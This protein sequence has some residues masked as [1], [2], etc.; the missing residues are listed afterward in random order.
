MDLNQFK[1]IIQKDGGKFIIVENDKPT[2]IVMSFDEY[3]GKFANRN[4]SFSNP[5][6][7]TYQMGQTAQPS[8][9]GKG[10]EGKEREELTIDDLPV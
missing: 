7:Q 4:P 3:K 8:S 5:M 6:H 10:E 9:F 2:L 1:D